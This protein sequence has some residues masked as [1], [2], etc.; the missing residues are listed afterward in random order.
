MKVA[1]VLYREF[2]CR[3]VVL[4]LG[5]HVYPSDCVVSCIS[6]ICAEHGRN[7][8]TKSHGA[9]VGGIVVYNTSSCLSPSLACSL[10]CVMTLWFKVSVVGRARARV[11]RGWF[12]RDVYAVRCFFGVLPSCRRRWRLSVPLQRV[13]IRLRHHTY[14]VT[15]M[16]AAPG[17]KP[18]LCARSLRYCAH[19]PAK[20]RLFSSLV[21]R[22]WGVRSTKFYGLR[23][24]LGG[25]VGCGNSLGAKS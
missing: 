5:C 21:L 24:V 10:D 6:R 25:N 22:R 2:W 1:G 20:V 15:L 11:W 12:I 14:H 8:W 19:S 23:P 18:L 4:V 13:S 9:K 17:R 3:C 16:L 7:D